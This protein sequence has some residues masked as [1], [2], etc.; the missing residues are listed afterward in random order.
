VLEDKFGARTWR[1][2]DSLFASE[3]GAEIQ[4]RHSTAAAENISGVPKNRPEEL[5]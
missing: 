4:G 5:H 2:K 1:T 3:N